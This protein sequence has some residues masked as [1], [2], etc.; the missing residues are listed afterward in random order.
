MLLL[1]GK[2]RVC[3]EAV[4]ACGVVKALEGPGLDGL[5]TAALSRG[6]VVGQTEDGKLVAGESHLL[7]AMLELDDARGNG[8]RARL[9]AH[10][11]EWIPQEQAAV[12]LIGDAKGLDEPQALWRRQPIA[13][14]ALQELRLLLGLELTEGEGERRTDLA[15]TEL[16]LG[17]GRE[18]LADGQAS[19][20]PALLVAQ[21]APDSTGG[22]PVLIDERSDHLPLVERR[23]CAR[24]RIGEHQEPLLLGHRH[25]TLENGGHLR[26]ALLSPTTQALEAI[27]DFEEAVVGGHD[28]QRQVRQGLE[29]ELSLAGPQARQARSQ[30]VDG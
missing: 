13:V 4:D 29:L 26:R 2:A 16:L 23:Q 17:L 15:A 10:A 1:S 22:E 11:A 18:A 28:S 20:D 6:E 3:G 21:E 9:G 25:R 30:T 24:R 5:E 27:E 19:L 14:G 8:R 12:G 7:E